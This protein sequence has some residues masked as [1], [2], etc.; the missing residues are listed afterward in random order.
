MSLLNIVDVGISL[1]VYECKVIIIQ[2]VIT[3]VSKAVYK[4]SR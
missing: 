4:W 3:W 1:D 2:F